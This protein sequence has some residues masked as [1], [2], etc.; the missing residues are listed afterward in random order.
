MIDPFL[1]AHQVAPLSFEIGGVLSPVS[2]RD[3]MIRGRWIVDRCIE[4]GLIMPGERLLLV[5]AGAAGVT[6]AIEGVRRGISVTLIDTAPGPFLRQAGCSSRWVDPTQYDWPVD[7]WPNSQF[8]W[9]WPTM[10]LPWT[11]GRANVLAI[12]WQLA[13]TAA[14][15]RHGP[16]LDVRFN[17]GLA[18]FPSVAYRTATPEL[19]AAFTPGGI[20]HFK[21]AVSTVG[22]GMERTSLGTFSS[23]RF[24]DTDPLE[25]PDYGL[26]GVSPNI[27][28]SGGGDGALQDF[29]RVST[30]APSARQIF[31]ALP[32]MPTL[33]AGLESAI[34]SAED[35]AQ[36]AYL[37]G[38]PG[39]TAVPARDHTIHE[40]LHQA[41]VDQIDI[42]AS[43][44]RVWPMI[45]AA[46]NKIVRSSAS[47]KLCLVYPCGHFDR[48]YAL[49]RFLVLLLARYYQLER[50][51]TVL[52]P[53]TKV[54][55]VSGITHTCA[56]D[57]ASC[58]GQTHTVAYSG[59]ACQGFPGFTSLPPG[60][61]HEIVLLR[62]G[63]IPPSPVYG[64]LA[65]A[66]QFPRQ[67]I[68]YYS[69]W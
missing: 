25:R 41:F 29:I 57:P 43:Y 13:L 45:V 46:L 56:S 63:I 28:I 54:T 33:R 64:P 23:Y 3:Q 27:L 61:R 6:A 8:P 26:P 11:A 21:I 9:T 32:L 39:S 59:S 31:D 12:S 40:R 30:A 62:H 42:L 49:N 37:W 44:P 19:S 2:I 55:A 10:P 69:P 4:A 47:A 67:M 68:P 34:Q 50:G 36:R 1:L 20:E 48:C 51:E 22:F 66:I 14:M 65:V 7:H 16:L 18:G 15:L 24:W 58:Y 60:S 17:T 5:G 53:N 35:Q 38:T 52:Y